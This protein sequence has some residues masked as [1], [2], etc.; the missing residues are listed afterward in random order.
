MPMRSFSRWIPHLFFIVGI[1]VLGYVAV[2]LLDAKLY[3]VHE[4]RR[5]EQALK[6]RK[7]ATPSSDSE[8]LK[9]APTGFQPKPASACRTLQDEKLMAQGHDLS[10][11]RR[12]SPSQ[13]IRAPARSLVQVTC[14]D[15][16]FPKRS[17][18]S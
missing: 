18:G 1:F 17:S 5:F 13:R 8:S 12:V 11:K 6:A 10:L 3:Q 4:A 2:T 15:P 14:G 16:E 9:S 7:N